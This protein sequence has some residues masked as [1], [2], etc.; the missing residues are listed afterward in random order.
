MKYPEIDK[1]VAEISDA[2]PDRYHWT[3]VYLLDGPNRLVLEAFR[4]EPTPHTVI[5]V[6]KGI[7]GA[8][9]REGKT[10]NIPD[11]TRDE[12][13]IS[14][15]IKTKSEIVVPIWKNGKIVGE[16]DI[17]S[18]VFDAFTD[19]DEIYLKKFAERIAAVLP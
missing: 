1:I 16:I 18:H 13:Y 5:P 8:A 12:R 15:S 6:D 10:L 3:G 4:G 7:C 17:D 19:E 14:C 11:V 9:V 2:F